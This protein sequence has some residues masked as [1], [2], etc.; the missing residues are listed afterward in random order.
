MVEVVH[1]EK[2]L[3]KVTQSRE[4]EQSTRE[5]AEKDFENADNKLHRAELHIKQQM[6]FVQPKANGRGSQ[7]RC[8]STGSLSPWPV[9]MSSTQPG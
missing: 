7:T 9:G 2:D 6:S 1:S 3:V 8:V 4:A 5:H